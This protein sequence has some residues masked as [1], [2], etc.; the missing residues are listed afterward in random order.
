MLIQVHLV[1]GDVTKVFLEECK[2]RPEYNAKFEILVQG[3]RN[4]LYAKFKD[5]HEEF[6]EEERLVQ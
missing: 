2:R 6:M 4:G 3:K 5:S 1:W